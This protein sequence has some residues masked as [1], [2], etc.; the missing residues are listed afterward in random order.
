VAKVNKG[1]SAAA[2]ADPPQPGE[3][4]SDAPSGA[5]KLPAPPGKNLTCPQ[6]LAYWQSVPVECAARLLGYLYRLQPIIDLQRENPDTPVY[7]AKFSQPPNSQDDILAEFGTGSY[8]LQLT[9]ADKTFGRGLLCEC[10]WSFS[11]SFTT[12]PPVL[13]ISALVVDHKDNKRYVEYL[14]SKGLLPMSGAAVP[15]TG[16]SDAAVHGLVD[17]IKQLLPRAM[18]LRQSSNPSEQALGKIVEMFGAA[19]KA[20]LEMALGQVRQNSPEDTL[21]LLT[22]LQGLTNREGGGTNQIMQL[23]MTQLAAAEKRNGELMLELLKNRG[24][25]G[26]DQVAQL[27]QLFQSWNAMMPGNRPQGKFAWLEPYIPQ[28]FGL[29]DKLASGLSM[30]GRANQFAQRPMPSSAPAMAGTPMMPAHNG[31]MEPLSPA[32]APAA[33][34]G[35]DVALA[36]QSLLTQLWNPMMVQINQGV[37]GEAFVDWVVAGYNVT[38]TDH[39]GI[40]EMVNQMGGPAGVLRMLEYSNPGAWA[41]VAPIQ[42]QFVRFLEEFLAWTPDWADGDEEVQ[43]NP[44]PDGAVQ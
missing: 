24:N 5:V 10:R 18:E 20:S 1:G 16:T 43:L 31:G 25:N 22:L 21:K 19:N 29:A 34:Q 41:Q 15:A 2:V 11:E 35:G 27:M 17:T 36:L 44:A 23:F 33:N 8:K 14:R 4:A 3:T 32:A 42:P 30:L 13:P 7:I 38:V 39:A 9:D 12:H 28:A 6:L 37:R 40:R 26:L